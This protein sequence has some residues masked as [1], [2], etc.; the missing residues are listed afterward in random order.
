MHL[1]RFLPLFTAHWDI[2]IRLEHIPGA[3][4]LIPDAL[5]RNHMQEFR[6]KAPEAS[7][8]LTQIPWE[9][10]DLLVGSK[11]DWTSPD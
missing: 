1:L 3:I 6:Q 9:L 4:N 5:S 10:W 8:T 7:P 2:V 11:P